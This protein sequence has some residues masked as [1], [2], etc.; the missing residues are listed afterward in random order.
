MTET[1]IDHAGPVIDHAANNGANR[2]KQVRNANRRYR[3]P[4]G[5]P[6]LSET[7]VPAPSSKV[8]TP[9]STLSPHYSESNRKAFSALT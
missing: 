1:I 5:R 8:A 3:A 4:Q 2:R 7:V 9:I 6:G